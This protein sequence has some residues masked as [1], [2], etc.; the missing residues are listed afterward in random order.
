MGFHGLVNGVRSSSSSRAR[1]L[2]SLVVALLLLT[3]AQVTSGSSPAYAAGPP[4]TATQLLTVETA[5][6]T[7]TTGVLRGW[8]RTGAGWRVVLGPFPVFVGAR[9]VGQASE[10]SATT[11]AGTFPLTE[12]FGRQP[13]PGT[14]MPWF[15]SDADDWWDENPSS[16][17]YNQHVRRTTSPGGASE[18]LYRSGA[19]YDYAVNI[20]YNLARTPGAGSAIFLHV[21]NGGPTAA[22]VSMDRNALV[23]VLRWLRPAADPHIMINV[24]PV[25]NAI[26]DNWY[27][28]GGQAGSLRLPQ[29]PE[30]GTPDRRG[31]YQWFQGGAVYWSARTGAHALY[32]A[33]LE[34]WA[35]SGYEVGVHG[36]PV[37]DE[38]VTSGGTGAFTWFE[39]GA[40][41][42][43]AA[44]GA[45]SVVNA[46]ADVWARQGYETGVLGFPTTDEL[47]TRGGPGVYQWFQGGAVYWSPATGAQPVVGGI[48][49]TWA[50]QGYETGT[51]GFPTMG[52]RR[53]ADGR[54]T[55]QWFQ[56]GAVYAS[57]A[58]GSHWLSGP[59]LGEWARRGYETG[60]L[61]FPVSDA[62]AVPGGTRVDFQGGSLTLNAATGR[63]S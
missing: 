63:I 43:S 46:V 52:E 9:G 2:C 34:R 55:Y 18:N 24:V 4:T 28:S 25:R 5:S 17:T 40:I 27:A 15:Q 3:V 62:Y 26:A 20:G 1:V 42:W 11:P 59:L 8:E 51:L 31:V 35:R 39:R 21:S 47:G 32:N 56:G 50:G 45:H 10:G 54:G 30:A 58:S 41:Y 37:T 38:G 48:A 33:I 16:P 44:T 22:C 19:V 6:S 57:E 23:S 7:A 60:P 12:A 36:Y 13:N 49:A 61:G 53:T 14:A 29:G